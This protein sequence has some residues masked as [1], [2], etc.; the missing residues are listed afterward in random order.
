MTGTNF[1]NWPIGDKRKIDGQW[2]VMNAGCHP[3]GSDLPIPCDPPAIGDVVGWDGE[4]YAVEEANGEASVMPSELWEAMGGTEVCLSMRL[5]L[6]EQPDTFLITLPD[7]PEGC[8]WEEQRDG[9]IIPTFERAMDGVIISIR[10]TACRAQ[11]VPTP[12]QIREAS[13]R[14]AA[15]Q[16]PGTVAYYDGVLWMWVGRIDNDDLIIDPSMLGEQP[17]YNGNTQKWLDWGTRLDGI[18]EQHV[19]HRPGGGE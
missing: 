12:E 9:T 18:G 19:V 16:V 1:K 14:W 2:K 3:Y 13:Q 8:E 17:I 4:R 7:L 5:R 10:L 11:Q 6:I 15:E